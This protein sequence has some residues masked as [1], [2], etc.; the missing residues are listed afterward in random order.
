[1]GLLRRIITA[2]APTPT[3][4]AVSSPATLGKFGF[5]RDDP[6]GSTTSVTSAATAT[7]VLPAAAAPA[8]DPHGQPYNV[9]FNRAGRTERDLSELLGLAKGMLSDGVIT[10]DEATYLQSWCHNHAD[11]VDHWPANQI[12]A[13]LL[14][15]FADGQI[16]DAE[17]ADLR[18]LLA[19]LVGGTASM[20]LGY[21]AA[22]TLPLDDPAPVCC[23][24]AQ[25]YVFTGRFAYGTRATCEREVISRGGTCEKTITR[26]TTFVVVG[27]FGS[28]DWKHSNYG[29]KIQKAVTLRDKGGALRIIGEDHWARALAL[30][31]EEE[32][33]PP[34]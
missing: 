15:A 11:A 13:R 5:S 29:G 17:R 10:A 22:S 2:I 25:V 14:R 31:P 27:T 30:T 3:L 33:E 1:M 21:E 26:R 8:F 12:G 24:P 4:D 28:R 16:D 32:E 9:L 34:F 18:D 19:A 20:V 23:W 6:P 7:I